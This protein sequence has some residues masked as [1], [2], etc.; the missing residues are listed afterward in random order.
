MRRQ[1]AAGGVT[2][3]NQHAVRCRGTADRRGAPSDGMA[4][5]EK[6]PQAI[7]SNGAGNR[8]RQRRGAERPGIDIPGRTSQILP[9]DGL[10]KR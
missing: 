10:A 9:H 5:S 6:A 7:G 3:K 4:A 2:A 8:L 1:F